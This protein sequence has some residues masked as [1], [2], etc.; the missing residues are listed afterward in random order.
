[1]KLW[2][3]TALHGK[4]TN[5]IKANRRALVGYFKNQMTK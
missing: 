2:Q 4:K 1:M 3:Y 5:P